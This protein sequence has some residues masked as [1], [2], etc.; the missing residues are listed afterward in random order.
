MRACALHRY[1]VNPLQWVLQALAINQFTSRE[2]DQPIVIGPGK[3]E[4]AGVLFLET[5]GY[6]TE[7]RYIW[8][9][10]LVL[11]GEYLVLTVVASIAYSCIR[12]EK[13]YTKQTAAQPAP[14]LGTA[15]HAKA[16]DAT[17]V[18]PVENV[19][20]LVVQVEEGAVNEQPKPTV[21]STFD[22]PFQPATI[23][24]SNL[25]YTI[26]TSKGDSIDLLKGVHGYCKPGT[27]MALMGSS[28]GKD[29]HL[30]GGLACLCLTALTA[31]RFSLCCSLCSRQDDAA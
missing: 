31:N 8:Y 14:A 30:H 27:L 7:Q 13:Q 21:D 1:W 12:F 3:T 2:Y 19:D 26:Q 16:L 5:F 11:L 17:A 28:G 4:K 23:A 24:F 9:S 10:I 20:D 22:L 29:R 15:E 6:E 18:V 25:W